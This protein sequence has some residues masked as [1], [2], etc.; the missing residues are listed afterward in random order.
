MQGTQTGQN[1]TST[2]NMSEPL[3]QAIGLTAFRV[4]EPLFCDLNLS[5]SAGQ[6]LQIEGSNGSGKTTLLRI[7]C[8]LALADEG[9]ILWRGD[10]IHRQRAEF[11]SEALFLGHKTG[12]KAEL[13]A[14]ENL[15][16]Y[17]RMSAVPE[18]YAQKSE[19]S[20]L[21][22]AL[23]AVNLKDHAQLPCAVLSAG[24]QRRVAL[25]RLLISPATLWILDEPLTA[26]DTEGRDTVQRV[27]SE[28]VVGGGTLIYT[29]HQAIPI[30][31]LAGCSVSLD[32]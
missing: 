10:K 6:L 22:D 17:Q 21:L 15:S 29:T 30:A 2:K 32:A 5:V 12:I 27:L 13:S 1:D 3:L 28:H 16:V 4:D 19:S 18:E 31:G 20:T 14:L 24:Q 8:G 7:L 26:L 9:E 25:A 11:F 23:S